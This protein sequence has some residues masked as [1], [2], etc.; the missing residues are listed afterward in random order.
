[1]AFKDDEPL[2]DGE[3]GNAE[4]PDLAVAPWLRRRPFDRVVEVDRFRKRPGLVLAGRFAGAAAIDT[5]GGIAAR[6]PPVRIDRFPIH[7]FVG[8][9]FE[10]VRHDPKL[11]LLIGAEIENGGKFPPVLRTKYIRLQPHAVAHR[12]IEVFF[13]DDGVSWS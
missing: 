10:R 2:I 1:M 12:H 4:K 11:V 5:N 3:V 8:R 13:D 9:L 6:H 7:P